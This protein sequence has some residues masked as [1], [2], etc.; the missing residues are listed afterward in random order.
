MTRARQAGVI[1]ATICG[2]ALMGCGD[3]SPAS[4]AREAAAESSDAA[5]K[6]GKESK[7]GEES[8]DDAVAGRKD[9]ANRG[10]RSEGGASRGDGDDSAGA[11]KSGADGDHGDSAGGTDDG[12]TPPDSDA[13]GAGGSG[14]TPSD[15]PAEDSGSDVESDS[16]APSDEPAPE[17][18]GSTPDDSHPGPAWTPDALISHEVTPTDGYAV[19]NEE[20]TMNRPS[21]ADPCRS[22]NL[23]SEA[24]REDRRLLW[25]SPDGKQGTSPVIA[26]DGISY[27]DGAAADAVQEI[28]DRVNSC[29]EQSYGEGST[30]KLSMAD[31]DGLISDSVVVEM[32][33]SGNYSGAGRAVYQ[34]VDDMVVVTF[35]MYELDHSDEANR[36][37]TE[38]AQSYAERISAGQ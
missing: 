31:T 36:L 18:D 3:E 28:R 23:A 35:A 6:A 14:S 16:P 1:V 22:E 19:A 29:A 11:D 38:L 2:L 27:P 13:G 25:W 10:H 12:S 24:A 9:G 32:E 34:H 37:V 8:A 30:L 33:L 26:V 7:A 15:A 17:S 21:I 5:G 4:D 20:D